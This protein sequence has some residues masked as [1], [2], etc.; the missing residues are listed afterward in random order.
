[1]EIDLSGRRPGRGVYLCPDFNCI[2]SAV[3]KDALKHGLKGRV[4]GESARWLD[5]K[6]TILLEEELKK[7]SRFEADSA[8]D[9]EDLKRAAA[10]ASENNKNSERAAELWYKYRCLKMSRK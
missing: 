9:L 2:K 4:E 7:L 1:L 3:K 8:L 10:F 5:E 6:I